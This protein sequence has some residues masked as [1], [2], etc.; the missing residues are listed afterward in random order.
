MPY[1]TGLTYRDGAPITYDPADYVAAFD[2]LLERARL[3]GLARRAGEAHAGARGPSASGSAPTSRAPGSGPSRAPT[4]ASIP[5]GTVFVHLGVCAQGQGHETTL[6]QIVRRRAGGA[7]RVAWSWWAATPAWSA[8][9]WARSRAA[10]PRWRAPRCSAPPREVAHK[11]R[12]VA[13]ELLRVRARGRRARRRA[14]ARQGRARQEPAASA[15]WR[16]P[17]C[18]A[19]RWR[20]D[21]RP[22]PQRLRLLLSRHG[23]VGLRRAGRRRRG[24]RRGVHAHA[25]QAR[26]HARLRAARSTR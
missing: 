24:G 6:A 1:R 21:G 10:W 8:T 11:A 12:L 23:H 13:A 22:G 3:R 18:G 9:A 25:A 26:R 16:A 19:A 5:D 4:C 15:R 17:R 7:A 2:R 14:R 20:E